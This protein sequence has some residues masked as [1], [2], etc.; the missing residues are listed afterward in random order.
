MAANEIY[1]CRKLRHHHRRHLFENLLSRTIIDSKPIPSR[2]KLIKLITVLH[3]ILLAFQQLDLC[4]SIKSHAPV[5]TD[6]LPRNIASSQRY[7]NIISETS[8]S[9]QD[10]DNNHHYQGDATKQEDRLQAKPGTRIVDK[11]DTEVGEPELNNS[12]NQPADGSEESDSSSSD[13]PSSSSSSNEDT[14]NDYSS[15]S[16]TSGTT[17]DYKATSTSST[18]SDESDTI[19][20]D[21]PSSSDVT[22]LTRLAGSNQGGQQMN[23]P[24]RRSEA[25]LD[26][27]RNPKPINQQPGTPTPTNAVTL[28]SINHQTMLGR[29]R[30]ASATQQMQPTNTAPPQA[31][32]RRDQLA[33]APHQAAGITM[34]RGPQRS[35]VSQAGVPSQSLTINSGG[36][37]GSLRDPRQQQQQ[38]QLQPAVNA[39][40]AHQHQ[41]QFTT[42][43]GTAST[44]R[45]QTSE[46]PMAT[47]N[48]NMGADR[49]LIKPHHT[50]RAE[51]MAPPTI[52]TRSSAMN[53]QEMATESVNHELLMSHPVPINDRRPPSDLL[54]QSSPAS[55]NG[56]PVLL[57]R[58]N[59]LVDLGGGG[60]GGGGNSFAV[61]HS[62]ES[63]FGSRTP[64]NIALV[65]DQEQLD[66]AQVSV[67]SFCYTPLA[68]IMVIVVTMMITILVCFCT[69]VLI[70]HLGRHRFGKYGYEQC[71]RF[72]F[73]CAIIMLDS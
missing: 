42:S 15:P 48:L 61:R 40:T 18:L 33:P 32:I 55:P 24:R 4:Y 7:P 43:V 50:M 9:Q 56:K 46:T 28:G 8:R 3:C 65:A 22:T 68:L 41:H 23:A 57:D 49:M 16:S 59:G 37:G 1:R 27:A 54:Y 20:I 63:S 30:Q 6:H 71:E 19:D 52:S 10:N 25:M 35:A 34:T 13:G 64:Q 70:R 51:T 31:Q 36:G 12:N 21:G 73:M 66:M 14:G 5:T 44:N 72:C 17:D 62:I 11:R 2:F 39:I 58:E 38:Q 69:H 67:P 45:P 47:F 60:G 26:L 53:Q 29:Q